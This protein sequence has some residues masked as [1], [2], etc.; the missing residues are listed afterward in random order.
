VR[1]YLARG[2]Y[3]IREPQLR[4]KQDDASVQS[5]APARIYEIERNG[6]RYHVS[7]HQY[8]LVPRHSGQIVIE[9]AT[10]VAHV[11]HPSR[12]AHVARFRSRPL[13]LQV[14]PA[15]GEPPGMPAAAWLPAR[16]LALTVL[17]TP[18]S[19]DHRSGEPVTV[20]VTMRA[21]G[22]HAS[23]LP[24]LKLAAPAGMKLFADRPELK[25]VPDSEGTRAERVARFVLLPTRPGRYPLDPIEVPWFNIAQERWE[26]A[27]AALPILE[28][29]PGAA[30]TT[31][32]SPA[33]KRAVQAPPRTPHSTPTVWLLAGLGSA[34]VMTFFWWASGVRARSD[35]A[36]LKRI[37][38]QLEHACMAADPLAA[39][40]ALI[41][42]G[43]RRWP[44]SPPLSLGGL[45]DRLPEPLASAVRTVSRAQYGSAPGAWSPHPLAAQLDA[46]RRLPTRPNAG[47]S[48]PLAALWPARRTEA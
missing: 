1:Q 5:I 8:S 41:L 38:K 19:S 30:T 12:G 37:V 26:V 14:R 36:F 16:S 45:A 6:R 2:A 40:D 7:E 39:R 22:T 42:W 24:N 29:A 23:D 18:N 17:L 13:A 31:S 48:E 35:G 25:D 43:E 27:R 9:P 3:A 28:V 33:S 34:G 32:T 46:L 10:L 4:V 20:T 44:T 21:E 11:V 15:T 47:K